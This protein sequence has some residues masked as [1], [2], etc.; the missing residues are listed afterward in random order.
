MS[1]RAETTIMHKR[2]RTDAIDGKVLIE[3]CCGL[4]AFTQ[5]PT[6]AFIAKNETHQSMH[7]ARTKHNRKIKETRDIVFIDVY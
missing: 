2:V 1:D 7:D 6:D 5:S 3:F 4:W